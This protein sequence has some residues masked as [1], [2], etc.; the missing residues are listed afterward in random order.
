MN[1]W[2]A[3]G[4]SVGFLAL[5]LA[6]CTSGVVEPAQPTTTTIV[7]TTPPAV[8]IVS[9]SP[10]NSN[11]IACHTDQESLFALAEEPEENTLNEGEG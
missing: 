3:T 5:F 4:L 7:S 6:S 1:K 8:G 10:D 9:E 11:C 2:V